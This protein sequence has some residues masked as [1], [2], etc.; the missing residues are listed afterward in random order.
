MVKFDMMNDYIVPIGVGVVELG[1]KAW[2]DSRLKTNPAAME[3]EPIAPYVIAIGGTVARV[4]NVMTKW[5]ESIKMA[6]AASLPRVVTG[7]YDWV[8]KPTT[9]VS[10]SH[11]TNTSRGSG[12]SVSR[13]S[14]RT[15]ESEGIRIV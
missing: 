9:P 13:V 2:D 5:D 15:P 4:A 7:L 1:L 3:Y 14:A 8:K 6:V 10:R 11:A 12:I